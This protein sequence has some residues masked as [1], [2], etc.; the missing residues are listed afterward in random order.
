[1]L[2]TEDIIIGDRIDIAGLRAGQPDLSGI[3]ASIYRFHGRIY[4]IVIKGDDGG[5]T[6]VDMNQIELATVH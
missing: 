2:K 1:M 3:V 6:A 5:F 4:K